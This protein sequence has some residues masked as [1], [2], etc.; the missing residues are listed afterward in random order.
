MK[1]LKGNIIFAI[2]FQLFLIIPDFIINFFW[3]QYHTFM[4]TDTIKELIIT[5][6]LGL[7]ISYLPKK[8][9]F[10]FGGSFILMGFIQI[11]YFGYFRSYL[12]PYQI[13]LVFSEYNDIL[14]SLNAVYDLIIISIFIGII[15]L[16]VINSLNKITQTNKH[17]IKILLSIFLVF[18]FIVKN[19]TPAYTPENSHFSYIN[20]Y[21]AT[22]LYIANLLKQKKLL[23]IK[24]Y[25]VK[26]IDNGKP[27]VLLIIGESLNY[28][29]MNLFGWELNNTPNLNNLKNDKNFIYKKAIS[30]GVNTP[31]SVNSI[32][33]LKR[34]PWK[35]SQQDNLIKLANNNGYS[36][37]WYSMQKDSGGKIGAVC[38]YAKQFKEQKDYKRRYDDELLKDLKNIDF[39]KK[40]FV[41]LH[42]RANHSPYEKYTPN[43]F[44]KWK[45]NY[46]DYHKK[47]YFSY[48]D[49]VLYIDK[50]LSDIISYM[51]N[52]HK[53]FVIYF[54]SDH[55]EMLGF[56]EENGKYGHSKLDINV[57]TI[58]FLYYSDKYQK[59]F[60]KKIYN[61]YLI[62]K[63]VANDLGYKVINPN[64]KGDLYYINNVKLDGSGGWIEYNLSNPFQNYKKENL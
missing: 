11:V 57:A 37:Y 61:Q 26:K 58:P 25:E 35:L 42:F 29:R 51:K 63:M 15:F 45:F 36:T 5:F 60:T 6:L 10:I 9:K 56:K 18:P 24:K 38:F 12:E 30:S 14:I 22:N 53:N 49:S 32:F 20:T 3:K 4:V 44:Y 39:S 21:F 8:Y 52:N 13:G 33:N 19:N 16:M 46:N 40:S 7:I 17:S 48:M 54:I 47:A 50:V 1:N 34:E 59:P 41:V 55:A 27:I 62:S 31:V 64:E 43:S 2:V 28:K 23:P